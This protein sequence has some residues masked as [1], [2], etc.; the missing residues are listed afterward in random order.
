MALL[1]RARHTLGHKQRAHSPSAHAHRRRARTGVSV[2]G[3]AA[4]K[5]GAYS[6]RVRGGAG[7]HSAS[8]VVRMYRAQSANERSSAILS[9]LSSMT[10]RSCRRA[11]PRQA[12]RD[13][14]C[15]PAARAARLRCAVL[16]A[17]CA[18]FARSGVQGAA[19]NSHAE[20]RPMRVHPHC[21][22]DRPFTPS[23][24]AL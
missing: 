6:G 9:P 12:R 20:F 5:S 17:A 11:P 22:G 21:R 1:Q 19:G 10:A 14:T 8:T 2:T 3:A 24:P 16:G 4:E 7:P 13:A 15:P 18:P 23:R